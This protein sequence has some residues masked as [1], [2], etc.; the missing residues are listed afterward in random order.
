MASVQTTTGLERRMEIEV[1]AARIQQ[2]IDVRLRNVGRTARLQGFRPGKVPLSVVRQRFGTQIH[3]EVIGELVRQSFAE[4]VVE[5]KLNPA[6]GPR[7][8][9]LSSG[10]GQDF[11]YSATFEVYPEITLRGLEG[12]QVERPVVEVTATDVDDM[13]SHLRERWLESKKKAEPDA[14]PQPVGLESASGQPISDE[15][16]CQAYG[17]AQ[18]GIEELRRQVAE[19][20]QREV[21]ETRRAQMKTQ[22][23][24][25]LLAANPLELPAALVE[26]QVQNLQIEAA[27]RSGARD[28]SQVPP[29]EPFVDPARRRVALGL[30]IGEI[31]KAENME[32]DR[33]QVEVRLEAL[34]SMSENPQEALQKYRQNHQALHQI[35]AMVLEQQVID[36]LLARAQMV[37]QPKSF[38]EFTNFGA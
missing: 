5:Q 34:A 36:W 7:I 17:V 25:R 10:E 18:G 24:D 19:N 8:E 15:E 33:A 32:P 23:L 28:V 12:L 22:I 38:K 1:P 26:S 21:E 14:A 9:P 13:L 16:F 31:I 20:M 3:S 27:R 30:L 4:A 6:G 37:E 2:E 29:R 35:E 11:K